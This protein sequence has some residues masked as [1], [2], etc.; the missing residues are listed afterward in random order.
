MSQ[1]KIIVFQTDNRIETQPPPFEYIP[2]SI[3]ANKKIC[4]H[5]G[6]EYIFMPMLSHHWEGKHASFGKIPVVYEFI[7]NRLQN[8]KNDGQEEIMVFLDTDAWI[9]SPQMLK[10]LVEKLSSS[11]EKQGCF[12]RDPYIKKNTYVNSGSFI[13]K[14]N[15]FSLKMYES[16]TK[17][18][19]ETPEEWNLWPWDQIGFSQ[20]I[21]DH[22]EHFWIF[23]PDIINSG[24][25]KILRHNWNKC[26]M[27]MR[28]D[29]YLILYNPVSNNRENLNWDDMIDTKEY[30][31]TN[32]T[33]YD[34][35]DF[36]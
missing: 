2:L 3:E 32:E 5:L 12:S 19:T 34:Y 28:E 4:L 18:V 21:Y 30:P 31:N 10:D 16:L 15:D 8:N 22:R 11:P 13:L 7:Q 29:L 33:G 17:H 27:K 9:Q 35:L 25:G 26:S 14:I 1:T 20:Y 36:N 23:V 24:Y 6:Y